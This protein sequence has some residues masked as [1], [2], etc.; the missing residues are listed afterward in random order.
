[1]AKSAKQRQQPDGREEQEGVPEPRRHAL[2]NEHD[3]KLKAKVKNFRDMIHCIACLHLI[4]VVDELV[5]L[6]KKKL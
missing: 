5:V 3:W 4:H 6:I 2:P 1:M